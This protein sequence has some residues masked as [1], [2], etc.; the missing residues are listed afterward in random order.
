[1]LLIILI[2]LL[3]SDFIIFTFI[4]VVFLCAL[5]KVLFP[6]FKRNNL[7]I[8]VSKE[9]QIVEVAKTNYFN[10]TTL[11]QKYKVLKYLK[12]VKSCYSYILFMHTYFTDR[13]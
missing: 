8:I 1:M 9:Y 4:Y 10:P 3:F 13:N 12:I 2:Y 7:I 6:I 5:E 11:P